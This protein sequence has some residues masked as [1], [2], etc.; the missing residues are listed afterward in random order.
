M[1]HWNDLKQKLFWLRGKANY[2]ARSSLFLA[3]LLCFLSNTSC[4]IKVEEYIDS[5]HENQLVDPDPDQI[6]SNRKQRRG[7]TQ[8]VKLDNPSSL[9][10][11]NSLSVVFNSLSL[12]TEEIGSSVT[13]A[14]SLSPFKI[15][16]VCTNGWRRVGA[17]FYVE[18]EWTTQYDISNYSNLLSKMFP[19]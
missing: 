5:E 12:A 17:F 4:F 14:S 19:E 13:F 9:K 10:Y 7:K 6:Y 18:K 16:F 15:F 3:L 1:I 2:N 11:P 8:D